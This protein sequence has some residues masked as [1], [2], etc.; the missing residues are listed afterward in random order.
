MMT[1]AQQAAHAVAR[2]LGAVGRRSVTVQ[3]LPREDHVDIE[4]IVV[5]TGAVED[6][7]RID[8][9]G[10]LTLDSIPPE[11]RAEQANTELKSDDTFGYGDLPDIS[12]LDP[13]WGKYIAHLEK[14]VATYP[15][16]DGD[17]IVLGPETFAI[18][19]RSVICWR[20]VNYVR[21]EDRPASASARA[22][23]PYVGLTHPD[24]GGERL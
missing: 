12:K 19:D 22:T 20:G 24:A 15:H 6:T 11:L 14:L 23:R 7:V 18:L 2:L 17:N 13:D 21:Q 10:R 4:V 9:S 16:E 3:M 8:A 5:R 1:P